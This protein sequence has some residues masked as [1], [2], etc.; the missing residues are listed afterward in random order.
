MPVA[1]DGPFAET[2]EVLA[3]FDI[4]DFERRE[5]AVEF[6]KK[7][8]VHEGHVSEIRPV[9]E[10]WW[11]YHGAGRG[12]VNK[13]ALLILNNEEAVAGL[14]ESEIDANVKHHEAAGVEYATLRGLV[15]GES[16]SWCGVR[17]RRTTEASTVRVRRGNA[18][19]ADGPFAETKEV[20]GGLCIVDC[21]SMNEAIEWAQKL[22]VRDD[23]VEVR[24]V[25]SMWWIY[26]G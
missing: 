19:L 9:H 24:P 26:H 6:C 17:L 4:I 20:V 2:K 8:C 15:R 13:F 7:R 25:R 11:T 22:V 12:D 21:A 5:E 23:A 14:S 1:T 16:L 10:M 18:L 3:G